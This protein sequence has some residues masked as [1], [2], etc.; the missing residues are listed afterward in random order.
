MLGLQA[1]C[2]ASSA[3]LSL[4]PSSTNRNDHYFGYAFA[5]VERQADEPGCVFE[6][7]EGRYASHVN[8]G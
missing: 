3:S 2:I 8:S 6:L 5:E 7:Q 1:L 4:C